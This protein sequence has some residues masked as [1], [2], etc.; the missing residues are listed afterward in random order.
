MKHANYL[1]LLA[2]LLLL[3][4]LSLFARPK[5]ERSV[6]LEET[7]RVAGTTLRP[8]SYK[9]AWQQNGSHVQ[10]NFLENGKTVATSPATLKTNDSQVIQDDIVT[11]DAGG[12]ALLKEIDFSH[13]KEALIFGRG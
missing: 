2:M 8:G 6:N 11:Q 10:V 3:F 12:H 7:V 4:P 9:V 1:A 5:N 13:Q